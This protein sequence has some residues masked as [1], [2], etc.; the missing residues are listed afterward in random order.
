MHQKFLD[1]VEDK[2]QYEADE[3]EKDRKLLLE[4]ERIRAEAASKGID[5]GTRQ[6]SGTDSASSASQN[7]D[8]PRGDA[9]AGTNAATYRLTNGVI[10]RVSGD[11]WP[12]PPGVCIANCE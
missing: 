8:V 9:L 7:Y 12:D 11:F 3:R 6:S 2:Q 5:T 10:L 4:L 1:V